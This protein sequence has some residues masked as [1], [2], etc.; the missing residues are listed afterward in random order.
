[1]R[2]RKK[3]ENATK[4][5]RKEAS[6]HNKRKGGRKKGS[7]GKRS[8]NDTKKQADEYDNRREKEGKTSSSPFRS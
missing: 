7:E 6:M 4:K 2:E 5:V 1:M 3:E 8:T